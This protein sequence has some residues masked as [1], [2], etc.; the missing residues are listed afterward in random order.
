MKNFKIKKNDG[1]LED[2]DARKHQR[3]VEYACEG[4]PGVS[5]SQIEM[6]AAASILEGTTSREIQAALIKAAAGNISLEAPDY[7]IAAARLLNQDIRSEVYGTYKPQDFLERFK[8]GVKQKYYDGKFLFNYYTE[9]EISEFGKKIKYE[10]DDLFVYSGLKKVSNSYLVRQ[11]KKIKETPQEMFMLIVM[12]AFAKYPTKQRSKWVLEGYRILSTFEASLPT[13]IMIQMRTL[14]KRLISCNLISPG[15]SNETLAN[16]S[17]MIQRL[18][19]AGAGLGIGNTVRGVGANID[20]GRIEHT[21]C[22]PIYKGYEKLTK[23]F[24]Q[25]SRDGSSTVNHPF[26]HVEIESF[27]VLG[28]AKGT[29]ETRIREMDHSIM[30]NTLFFE[31]YA[32]GQDITLFFMNDVLDIVNYMGDDIE[33][34]KRYE[35]AEATI[36]KKRQRKISADKIFNEFIDERFLQSREY[37]TFMDNINKQGLFRIPIVMSNLCHEITVPTFPLYD[38]GNFKRNIEFITPESRVEYYKLRQLAFFNT[39]NEKEFHRIQKRMCVLHIFS[40]ELTEIDQVDESKDFDYFTLNGLVNFS[41][42]GVCIL[43]GINMGYC[44]DERLPIVSEFLV[45]FLEETIDYG[46]YPIPEVEKSAKMRRTLGI[47]FSDVFHAMAKAKV[48]YN[49][50][51]GRQYISNRVELCSY[52][53]IRTSMELAKEKGPCQLI[54]DV[55]YVDGILPI[56]K[57]NKNVMSLIGPNLEFDLDWIDL[58][59]CLKA[60]GIRNST[61]MANAPYGSSAMVSNSTSGI[62]PPRGLIT[63]K[64]GNLKIVP[65]YKKYGK[66][67]TTAWGEDFDNIEYFKF[68]AVFQR[69]MDQAVSLNQYINLIKSGGKVKKSRLI[70]EVL[71]ARFYGHKTIYYSNI[72]STNQK[73]GDDGDDDIDDID[74]ILEEEEQGCASGGCIV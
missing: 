46:D 19:A 23:S 7:Q 43:G 30:F 15:D 52:H 63:S 5:A 21:G 48:F 60:N 71:T 40:T 70:E 3:Y 12:F 55:D 42:V 66:Y 64:L 74:D 28:N 58:R 45:R 49:T 35:H 41:E 68:A 47:G 54:N 20:N 22:L 62:E 25:P 38:G 2:Y 33:F 8:I 31:R 73:D 24:V 51:E 56:D 27:M 13:P 65:D 57:C 6:H 32:R 61:L 9:S 16:A 14:F 69:P 18:V 26:F 29:E 1:T 37:T 10:R 36:P 59:E 17:R 50:Q 11:H 72:R 4:L 53:M 67:Y 44:T 34:K 39:D